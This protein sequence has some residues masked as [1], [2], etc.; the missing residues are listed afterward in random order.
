MIR[1]KRTQKRIACFFLLLLTTQSLMPAVAWA[2][3]SGPVQPEVKQFAQAGTSDMVDL[4][5]GDFKYNIPLLDVDGYPVNLNYQSG[6]GM[7]DEAS[8]VGL[9][10]N[11]NVGALT[12]TLRGV[13]D[14]AF[15]DTVV[16][17]TYVKP[18]I[19]YG[20]KATIRGEVL[21]GNVSG[22]IAVGIFNDNYTGIGAELGLNAGLSLSMSNSQPLTPGIGVGLTSNTQDGVSLTPYV[23]LSAALAKGDHLSTSGGVSVTLG[24]NTREGLKSFGLSSS[25]S[26]TGSSEDG[27][28]KG[29]GS[30]G[31]G[32]A[33]VS[34]NTPP[35]YPKSNTSFKSRNFTFSLDVGAS[36]WAVY[37]GIGGTGYKSVR[38]VSEP[39]KKNV[40]Y[41]FLYAEQ[42]K[43][44][45]NALMDFMREKDNPV[46]PE[47]RNL[48]LPVATP[49]IWSYSSQTGGGQ[50]KLYRN[51]T[52]V[53]FDNQTGD[54]SDNV[55]LSTEFGAGAYFH[56]G[57]SVYKQDVN[58]FNGKWTRGNNFLDSSDFPSVNNKAEE[59]AYFKQVGE[60]RAEDATFAALVLDEQP[61]HVPLSGKNSNNGLKPAGKPVIATSRSY[62]KSG[63]Q[64]R[65]VA[66]SYTTV[67][68]DDIAQDKWLRAYDTLNPNGFVALSCPYTKSLTSIGRAIDNRSNKH[69][70]EIRVT[71]ADGKRV[72]YGIPVYNTKQEE[73]SFAV[74]DLTANKQVNHVKYGRV[75]EK[76]DHA[77]KTGGLST[78][79][80]YYHRETQPPYAA[81]YLLTSI[82]SP[83]Y[84]DVEKDGIT[85]DDRGTAVKF[86]YS[87]MKALYK[88]RSPWGKDSA[89]YNPGLMA[90]PDD[91]KGSIVYGEKELWYLQ[92][93]ET[94]TKIA[95]FLTERRADG[96][97]ADLHGSKDTSVRQRRLKEI[98]LYSKNDLST[99]IKTVVFEYDYGLCPGV[100]NVT[101]GATGKLRLKSVHFTYG[102]STKGSKH[103]YTF[104]YANNQPYTQMSTDRWGSFKSPGNNAAEGFA[105]K[106][107]EFPYTV[108]NRATADLN[109]SAWHLNKIT[110]P[111]GG[112][113]MVDYE[114]DDYAYVQDK[115]ATEMVKIE[116]LIKKDGTPATNLKDAA[117][118]EIAG[119]S[120][121]TDAASFS[122]KYL[123]GEKY[124]Y[125]KLFVNMTDDVRSTND[126]K[127]DFV[128][129]YA[130]V[131]SAQTVGNRVRIFFKPDT[132][133]VEANPLISTAW[134]RMRLEYQ[135]YAYPGYKNR[136]NDDRSV[137]AAVSALVNSISNMS[138]LWQNFNERAKKKNFASLV[139]L[140]KSFARVMKRDGYKTGGGA[141]VK[142]IRMSDEWSTMDNN[143]SS[144]TYGQ[145]YEYTLT[146]N[147]AVISSG[148]ASFE[149]SLGGDENALRQPVK[150]TQDVKWGLNN[151][152][153][154]EEPI[155]ESFYPAPQ[156]GY[157]EVKIRSLG[158]G[159]VVDAEN[160][161][162]W[163]IYEFYTA[164][165]FPVFVKQTPLEKNL[166]KPMSWSSFFG[167]KSVYELT[168]SQGYAVYLNDMHGKP[169]AERTFNAGGQEIAAT[170]YEY[171]ASEEG[172]VQR[173]KNVV[174]VVDETGAIVKDQVIGREIE[175]FAD[176][177]ES[178]LNNSGK[179]VNIG[180]DV[181]PV[182]LWI[183]PIPHFPFSL[184]DDY[185]LFRS[186]SVV[187]TIQYYG[188]MSRVTKKIN[189]S[190]IH[191]T[192][193]LYDKNTGDPVL[194]QTQNEFDDPV[195]STTIPAYWMYGQMGFAA[196]TQGLLMTDLSTADN[197]LVQSPYD[198]FLTE[199]DEVLNVNKGTRMWVA[200]T[201]TTANGPK[202]LRLLGD[203]GRA[204]AFN[205]TAKVVRS[206]YRNLLSAPATSIT[207]LKNPIVNNKLVLISSDKLSAYQVLNAS[208]VVYSDEWG[209]PEDC[210]A[211]AGSGCPTGYVDDGNNN[212]IIK[213]E[214]NGFG[215]VKGDVSKKYGSEGAFFF[216]ETQMEGHYLRS[217]QPYWKG[218][219]T[220]CGR[221][222]VAGVWMKD[223]EDGKWWGVEK[224]INIDTAGTYRIGYAADNL[225]AVYIDGK[226][227]QQ[228]KGGSESF[229]DSWRIRKKYLTAGKHIIRFDAVN[230][231]TEKAAALEI[232]A[233]REDVLA[234]GNATQIEAERVFTS[235][236]LPGDKSALI[237]YTDAYGLKGEQNYT[238]T[239]GAT[240]DMCDGSPNCGSVPKGTCPP[241]YTASADGQ[242]CVP[243]GA[244]VDSSADLEIEASVYQTFNSEQGAAF[245]DEKGNYTDR[246]TNSW[247]G[248]S[249]CSGG[250]VSS[251]SLSAAKTSAVKTSSAGSWDTLP[252]TTTSLAMVSNVSYAYC[253]RLNNVGVWLSGAFD[254]KW[255]GMKACLKVPASRTYYI[256]FGADNWCRIYIDDILWKNMEGT[257]SRL[258]LDWNL[259][260]IYL[261]AG[262]H[263]IT[264][265]AKNGGGPHSVGV[266]VYNNT[267]AEL[268]AATT[269]NKPNIIFSTR[270]AWNEGRLKDTY[271]KNT[272]GTAYER[273]RF[274]CPEGT[275]NVCQNPDGCQS[276]PIG[277]VLNP[278]ITGHK[279]NW[280]PY[281]EMALLV[282]RSGQELVE[283]TVAANIRHNGY[284]QS[285]H[286]YWVYNNGWQMA[287]N[288]DWVVSRTITLYNRQ[289]QDVENKDALNRY[290]AAR[291]GFSGALAAAVG[292]NMREREIFSEG[293]EDY[294]YDANSCLSTGICTVDSFSIRNALGSGYLGNVNAEE[295]HSGNYCLNLQG[296][297]ALKTYMFNNEHQ[298]GIYLSNNSFGEFF[299]QPDK[300]KGLRGFSPVQDR[301][302]VF[303]AWVN[304]GNPAGTSAGITV[305]ANNTTITLQ[306]KAAVEG[307]KLVEG[308]ID[309]S[310]LPGSSNMASLVIEISGTV[311]LDDVRIFPYDG[312]I[313]TYSYDDKT[314]RLMA[315]LDENNYATFYEYD[316]EG[317]L[318][319]VKKET[320]RGIMTIKENRSAYRR[321]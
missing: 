73:Y 173:L 266:E 317:T 150:Y 253:G 239:N 63:R 6:I 237:F 106:N 108:K 298:P 271:V 179:S 115:R 27:T 251:A 83:D 284:L 259:Y 312:Q 289:S 43:S 122:R 273:R 7:D 25:F 232:Y 54:Y 112:M 319:R 49:D 35:F 10:W 84:V 257:D 219:A 58:T 99:P 243:E 159:G 285:F 254:Q 287:T 151:Y 307:W 169:K 310:S 216:T 71:E 132:D 136:I 104:E 304:D 193:L 286:A 196:Q 80:E 300:W 303:S 263:T 305:K 316:D 224:C 280:L 215:L 33:S 181:I 59:A 12:R 283:N 91:D 163:Q 90:D 320:E 256:G 133:G 40:A 272:A 146:E 249:G 69:I 214:D 275:Y 13:A 231:E 137:A 123:N 152:F 168:M 141:R 44:R 100:Y 315:E 45:E 37:A 269:A 182:G 75:N 226:L 186:A 113:I 294:K 200:R 195:Y 89:Q 20:G 17:E 23:S 19:T 32:G 129:C 234:A 15:G 26:K 81:S 142:R 194:T 242:S 60:K 281:Q 177:R 274:N 207:S 204:A 3:T 306:K 233:S 76:I 264:I 268:M 221:L 197:G 292:A 96:I 24:Y 8:W 42:G 190:T 79:D 227:L 93:I 244:S 117:G 265:E 205:G 175:M 180:V 135:R 41:G 72:I 149:P 308:T 192:T 4:F 38:E 31:L 57:S 278:Y 131:E 288:T 67:G 189:G 48:P 229:Y 53:F 52:G 65:N 138:E 321:Q 293:F 161:T 39:V 211:A 218:C 167:G 260:P 199:G 77:P 209:Q 222:A 98:R 188:M 166:H 126:S 261:Q 223:R 262:E 162:G 245:Y 50:F 16:T 276:I 183:I 176:M 250:S 114:S 29:G 155:G 302:Y 291:Y 236:D 299:L 309:L 34:Y 14:D 56:G 314:L 241:G 103:P 301:K 240:L 248:M 160:K 51:G 187:K 145:E 5:T 147:N 185:R 148:V 86:N 101:D 212:C 92:T 228:F 252:A 18:K 178:E 120:V 28:H 62:K 153:Y 55:S 246:V 270:T 165:E 1:N 109:A 85:P 282:N 21:G 279:G 110:L 143:A 124:L 102:S 157:R 164:K 139:K 210:N 258:F 191:E 144:A 290:S 87:K 318:V 201:A 66:I 125:T 230:R 94:K 119:D 95:F 11:L 220:G 247:W 82:L 64:K 2:L 172:G 255:I 296:S 107:D 140:D 170:E 198:Q 171:N 174:D 68:E 61:V 105:L 184:N 311:K 22:S 128:P 203:N 208:A 267:R 111:T 158:A 130:Q 88:W 97:G 154:L 74:N 238:C 118:I 297:V 47:L 156:V 121:V 70:S 225:M 46:I 295:A 127:Y 30:W 206:G 277:V 213:P 235:A 313:K 202:R 134:Q 36:A 9:G 217:T 78:T 116:R